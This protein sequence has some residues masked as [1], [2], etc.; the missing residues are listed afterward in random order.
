VHRVAGCIPE[1][2]RPIVPQPAEWQCIGNQIDAAMIFARVNFVSVLRAIH[3]DRLYHFAV[4][5]WRAK[6]AESGPREVLE[7]HRRVGCN[8]N[9][10]ATRNHLVAGGASTGDN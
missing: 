4:A 8:F 2:I 6:E 1:C 5:V 9:D 7:N 3:R 10:S